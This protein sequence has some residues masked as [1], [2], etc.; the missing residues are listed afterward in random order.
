MK[1]T[2]KY[3]VRHSDIGRWNAKTPV[4]IITYNCADVCVAGRLL[5]PNLQELK[6]ASDLE[7]IKQMENKK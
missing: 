4:D 1:S 2:K 5:S 7:A 3:Y 6:R